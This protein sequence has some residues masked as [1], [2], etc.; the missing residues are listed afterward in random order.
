MNKK[1]W[2]LGLVFESRV[3]KLKVQNNRLVS[4]NSEYIIALNVE[5]A[6]S[7]SPI[8]S[9]IAF[10]TMPIT[11]VVRIKPTSLP[12]FSGIKRDFFRWKTD[13]EGL[14]KQGK[15][16][17]SVEVKKIQLLDSLDDRIFKDP[18]LSNYSTAEDLFRV[19]ENLYGNKV[20]IAM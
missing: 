13:W 12:K 17:G 1:H 8:D 18:R 10:Q 6:Q 16:T 15:P 3:K 2:T 14:Q 7:A 19:L 5:K 20:T 11:P 4:R 9:N